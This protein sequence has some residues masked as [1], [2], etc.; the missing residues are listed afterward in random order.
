MS[1]LVLHLQD[2]DLSGFVVRVC[3]GLG[4]DLKFK[5]LLLQVLHSLQ[6]FISAFLTLT[7]IL[8]HMS[9]LKHTNTF[10]F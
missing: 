6:R 4:L 8:L 5:N 3:F 7:Q 1:L 9:Q 10:T 2:F